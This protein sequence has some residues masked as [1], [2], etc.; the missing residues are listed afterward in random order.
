MEV[1]FAIG[2]SISST[3]R[4]FIVGKAEGS[5]VSD[6]TGRNLC[7]HV[8][9]N[10][11]EIA[12]WVETKAFVS[13]I[14]PKC[15]RK[16]N[17]T[18]V[19]SVPIS[20]SNTRTVK[21]EL[22]YSPSNDIIKRQIKHVAPLYQQDTFKVCSLGL[23]RPKVR[24]LR[25]QEYYD[26]L[27]RYAE[28]FHKIFKLEKGWILRIYIDSSLFSEDYKYVDFSDEKQW[29][30]KLESESWKELVESLKSKNG[31]QFVEFTVEDF[32]EDKDYHLGYFGTIARFFSMGDPD[33]SA[34]IMRDID[35][36]VI[37]SDL[38]N[39]EHWI[40]SGSLMHFYYSEYYPIH[41]MKSQ[42]KKNNFI[43]EI[44]SGWKFPTQT[45][46]FYVGAG[47]FAIKNM[48][49]SKFSSLWKNMVQDLICE[50][51]ENECYKAGAIK[52]APGLSY[53]IDEI[54]LN[55]SILKHSYENG[56]I[57]A[58]PLLIFRSVANLLDFN[59]MLPKVEIKEELFKYKII[60]DD[61]HLL[62]TDSFSPDV[63]WYASAFLNAINRTE[64]TKAL[65][66]KIG[67]RFYPSEKTNKKEKITWDTAY[68]VELNRL[69]LWEALLGGRIDIKEEWK[70]SNESLE[71]FTTHIFLFGLDIIKHFQLPV[72][73]L[74]YDYNKYV[75]GIMVLTNSQLKMLQ[76]ARSEIVDTLEFRFTLGSNSEKVELE[77]L[78][79]FSKKM[80]NRLDGKK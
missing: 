38:Q 17:S 10:A 20:S 74:F 11:E 43:L 66:M 12:S 39:I 2:S 13:E 25:Y 68:N 72:A 58:Y 53:G 29:N 60:P 54:V 4:L 21:I 3:R 28:G 75:E 57:Y 1:K 79:E 42:G 14:C 70:L 55:N 33:V 32:Q 80:L 30:G 9:D 24:N 71:R 6:E 7:N 35:S 62:I 64:N 77:E 46:R 36:N 40:Q 49:T 56:G 26:G 8:F 22:V 63:G 67:A 23:F 76:R 48:G 61:Q 65:E 47:L 45:P 78:I 37:E 18:N 73:N 69:I 34:S 51:D 41:A 31:I 16:K 50:I 59:M 19:I 52:A 44:P 15:E 5:F 27:M